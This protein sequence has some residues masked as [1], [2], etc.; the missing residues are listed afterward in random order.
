MNCVVVLPVAATT[1][2]VE[3]LLAVAVLL[4]GFARQRDLDHARARL[5]V[6]RQPVAPVVLH[7]AAEVLEPHAPL[8]V[9][10]DL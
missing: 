1:C 8:V 4:R 3:A 9:Q 6:A 7:E 10:I 5:E 2:L